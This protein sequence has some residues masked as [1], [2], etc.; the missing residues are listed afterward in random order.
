VRGIIWYKKDLRIQDNPALHH[1]CQECTDGV[2][3]VY[4]INFEMWQKTN[5]AP[6]QIEFILRNL[7]ELKNS[8]EKI[9]IPLL[10]SNTKKTID[11]SSILYSLS[12]Q[13]KAEKLFFNKE[14]EI[15]EKQS[16]A[17]VCEFL[18]QHNIPTAAYDN[19][20]ILPYDKIRT[21][22]GN[23]FK[24]FT[25]FK[26]EWLRNF[27]PIILLPKPKKQIPIHIISSR[28][29]L[30]LPGINSSIKSCPWPPGERGAN[31]VLNAFIKKNLLSYD[32]TRN[33]PALNATSQLSPYLA[34]GIISARTCFNAALVTNGLELDTGNKS[35]L[36][37]MSELIWRE[38]Y[39]HILVSKPSVCMSKAYKPATEKLPWRYDQSLLLAWQQGNTGFPII[40]AGMRQLNTIGWMHNR[41]RMI[42]AMFLSKNLFLDWRLGE[43][44]FAQHLIDYDFA[45]NNGGWQWSASTGTDAVPY[46]R[47]FNPTTQSERFDPSGEFIRQYCPELKAFDAY[48]IHAPHQRA[49]LLAIEAHYPKPIIDY[50]KSRQQA[51]IAFKTL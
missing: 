21:R 42:V 47:I 43:T 3:A 13:V 29:P 14:L 17:T 2:I 7:A 44:Y 6:L 26:R 48:S 10:L 41:L 16:E 39:R 30:K 1:A 40:D 5:T 22:S 28:V 31:K 49:P 32:K 36:T 46:F 12:Q 25:A 51:I 11:I 34:T 20:F 24:I 18:T 50:A 27:T 45:S 23:C 35:A 9:N 38:F 19:Q 37:W 33:F 8:L 15:Y 4:I